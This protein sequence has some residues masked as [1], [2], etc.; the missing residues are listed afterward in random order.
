MRHVV[1]ILSCWNYYETLNP[2]NVTLRY[3]DSFPDVVKRNK[4]MDTENICVCQTST[5]SWK[6]TATRRHRAETET[7]TI[8]P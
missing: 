5:S 3:N 8:R 1:Y 2:G 6:Y 7:K 4:G